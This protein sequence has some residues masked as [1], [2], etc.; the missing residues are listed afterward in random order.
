MLPIPPRLGTHLRDEPEVLELFKD[1]DI[2]LFDEK[3]EAGKS[4]TGRD[5][6]SHIFEVIAKKR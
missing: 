1:F 4:G 2:E 3:E 5:I 6:H